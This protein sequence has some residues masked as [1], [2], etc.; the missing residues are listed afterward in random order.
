MKHYASKISSSS[1]IS[2]T[3]QPI[4]GFLFILLYCVG[5][6]FIFVYIWL[7]FCIQL[8]ERLYFGGLVCFPLAYLQHTWSLRCSSHPIQAQSCV[9]LIFCLSITWHW[10]DVCAATL[11]FF[12]HCILHIQ[13]F[14]LI[15]LFPLVAGHVQTPFTRKTMGNLQFQDSAKFH[16][17]R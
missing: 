15:R 16:P 13:V 3:V 10:V 4:C 12:P 14:W 2:S 1:C 11:T 5:F 17:S 8:Q 7:Q 9:R 6:Y